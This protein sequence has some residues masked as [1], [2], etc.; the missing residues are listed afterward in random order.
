MAEIMGVTIKTE[1]KKKKRR[2][3]VTY[4]PPKSNTWRAEEYK[5]MQ[6]EVIK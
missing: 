4:V 6:G 3:I 5:E 2:T 1:K